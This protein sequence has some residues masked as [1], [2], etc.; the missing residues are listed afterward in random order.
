MSVRVTINEANILAPATILRPIR[1]TNAAISHTALRGRSFVSRGKV[2]VNSVI[3]IH[4]TNSVVPRILYMGRRA[5][6]DVCGFPRA[7]PDYND[8]MVHRRKRTTVEYVG[9]SYPT[10]LLE[11][12]VRF[13]SHSTVS[14]RNLNPTVV[15]GFIGYKLVARARS[16]C[17]LAF[18][19]VGS[20][21]LRNFGRGDV[22]GVVLSV[23]GSGRGSLTG[24]IFTLNVERVNTGTTG[25][26]SSRFG[27]VSG[28]VTTSGRDVLTV[29]NFN[30]VVTRDIYRFFTGR[31]SGRLITDLTRTNIGVGSGSIIGS[32]HFTNGVF[33]LANAL[34]GCAHGRTNSVVRDFNN[35]ASSDISGGADCILTNTRTN[36]GLSGTGTLNVRV[37]DRRRFARLVG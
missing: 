11:G 1:L 5:T 8:H 12:L 31:G 19:R 26:L 10:R 7:Y 18:S 35:G 32:R 16:V 29:S 23:R 13:Y 27:A 28:V 21:R 17:A 25:L 9:P 33:I 36:D 24:L 2:K 6:R 3:A 34:R 37:L 20:V 22:N 30:S 15:R 4:G 14:V